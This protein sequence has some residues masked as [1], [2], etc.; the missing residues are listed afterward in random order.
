M[1]FKIGDEVT[2]NGD[3]YE[4]TETDSI[5]YPSYWIWKVQKTKENE[6]LVRYEGER[7]SVTIW[8]EF[9]Y[10]NPVFNEMPPP[11][12]KGFSPLVKEAIEDEYTIRSEYMMRRIKEGYYTNKPAQIWDRIEK[13]NQQWSD[14]ARSAWA[15]YCD[16]I[17]NRAYDCFLD[18]LVWSFKIP[19][20]GMDSPSHKLWMYCIFA[21]KDK[22]KP[23]L[24]WSM[25]YDHCWWAL[26]NEFE[27]AYD[28]YHI[29]GMGNE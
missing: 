6:A 28:E 7:S 5:T 29:K 20:T 15:I 2:L 3:F 17:K 26:Y 25:E 18:D 1:K 12:T 10:L 27:K 24:T 21:A 8:I 4:D 22:A 14:K 9:Q 16:D 23:A 13:S 19:R 11:S